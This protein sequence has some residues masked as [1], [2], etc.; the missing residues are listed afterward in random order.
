MWGYQEDSK[1]AVGCYESPLLL[2]I[3]GKDQI[4][5]G[6]NGYAC[7]LEPRTGKPIWEY[8]PD[9]KDAKGG[10]FGYAPMTDGTNVIVTTAYLSNRKAQTSSCCPQGLKIE[11]GV[12]QVVW[13]ADYNALW[14][15]G[16]LK[17]GYVYTFSADGLYSSWRS[18]FRCVDAKTG[19]SKWVQ[20]R[21]GC[22]T[23]V[24]VDNCLL[25]LTYGGD[26][27]LVDPSPDGFKKIAEWKLPIEHEK[28]VVA[29]AP[30][31]PILPF[32][33]VPVVA[34]GKLY[35]R[36]SDLLVCYDLMK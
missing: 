6:A 36:Y 14:G 13:D 18:T 22:G 24:E 3:N 32:W 5:Y 2:K 11:N 7:G 8:V 1:R 34:R 10:I 15:D 20:E 23:L 29:G 19:T 33:T 35:V 12:A 30:D 17:N 25:C 9:P 26:L 21:T 28:W 4:V 31:I 27:W 16:I